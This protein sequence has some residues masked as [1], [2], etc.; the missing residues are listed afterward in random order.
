[1]LNSID[2]VRHLMQPFWDELSETE[3]HALKCELWDQGFPG[4][5]TFPML[6]QWA[7]ARL[8]VRLTQ[9]LRTAMWG[10]PIRV[11][12]GGLPGLGK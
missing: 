7:T 10:P 8:R 11:V 2:G 4:S 6:V 12:R 9:Q 3:R 5:Q 1:M